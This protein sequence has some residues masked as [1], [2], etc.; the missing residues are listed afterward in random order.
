PVSGL[1]F[2]PDGRGTLVSVSWDRSL[3]IWEVFRGGNQAE[4]LQLNSDALA[5]AF[6]P[7]GTEVCV[8]TLDGQLTFIDTRL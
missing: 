6:R 4:P 2:A 3:R 1:A 5:V 8:A 7:D